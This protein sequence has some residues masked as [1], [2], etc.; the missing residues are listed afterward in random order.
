MIQTTY[1]SDYV[2]KV[3][4]FEMSLRPGKSAFPPFTTPGRTYRFYNGTAVVPFGY[5]LSYTKFEYKVK[6]PSHASLKAIT[7]RLSKAAFEKDYNLDTNFVEFDL[8]VT[9]TGGVDSDDVVLGFF[10]PPG[11]G[12][13]GTPLK[14][15]Y[16]FERVFV[17]KGKSARVRFGVP[18]LAFTQIQENGE[19]IPW[20]GL[21]KFEFGLKETA[22][23]KMGYYEHSMNV[24]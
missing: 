17:P 6:G 20:P 2:N 13:D 4:L 11:A 18:A 24:Y 1:P 12:K 23:F 14:M 5:G 22:A 21:Y 16:N 3:S 19:R 8:N 10:V 15:L 9:N 7:S